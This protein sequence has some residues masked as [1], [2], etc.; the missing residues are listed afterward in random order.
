MDNSPMWDEAL[1][2]L[3]LRADEIPTYQRADTHLV[4]SED[5]PISAAYDRFAWLV[6]FF[7]QRDYDEAH[8]R[9]D[10]PFLV[11]DVLFNALLCQAGRDLAEISRVLG[12]DPSPHLKLAE[13]TARAMNEKLWNG[14]RSMYLDFDLVTGEPIRVY[15]AAGFSPLYAGIP[16][17]DRAKR[18]VGDLED[19]GFSLGVGPKVNGCY[20]V[21]SYDR[22]G[23]GFSPVQYWRGPVW[24]NIN[25]LL[26]RGLER[27]GF[28]DQAG[29]LRQ[30]TI[31]MVREGGFYEYFHPTR[32][33]GHGSDLFSWT[34]ALILDILLDETPETNGAL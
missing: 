32:G 19:S 5:R 9:E 27:Y 31:E 12:E 25:W 6:Q 10:C 13:Q 17:A 11:Q 14:E 4:A 33:I 20:P 24:V 29:H 1:L 23:Y 21:A 15:V 18:M 30:A 2:R 16:D 28:E 3:H 34:A 26:L 7:A 8:I 22:Y